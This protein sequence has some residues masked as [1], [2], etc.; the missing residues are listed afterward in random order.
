[1]KLFKKKSKS[2]LC[3]P[4]SDLSAVNRKPPLQPDRME[5]RLAMPKPRRRFMKE[6]WDR[7]EDEKTQIDRLPFS[8]SVHEHRLHG[9]RGQTMRSFEKK[10]PTAAI[11]SHQDDSESDGT[12]HSARASLAGSIPDLDSTEQAY[13]TH[14]PRSSS[15]PSEPSQIAPPKQNILAVNTDDRGQLQALKARIVWMERQRAN[16]MAER[17]HMECALL[18]SK[19]EVMEA[20]IETQRQLTLLLK[21]TVKE[22]KSP[23]VSHPEASLAGRRHLAA[24]QGFRAK[25]PERTSHRLSY[26]DVY[27]SHRAYV[28]RYPLTRSNKRYDY[29]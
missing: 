3:E 23:S 13:P 12:Y 15:A 27:D 11:D 24:S 19:R 9:R 21:H 7:P 2:S 8:S 6:I 25:R 4:F 18:N 10:N 1:M 14:R 5:P 26:L 28:H 17:Q 29:E 20:L 16:E 22:K